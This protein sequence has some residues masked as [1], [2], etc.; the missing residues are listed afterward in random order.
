MK[1]FL[2][3]LMIT[4]A[5]ASVASAQ[6]YLIENPENRPYFGAR[7]GMDITA[8]P[9][10]A[11]YSNYNNG[12]GVSFG[13]VYNIPVYKNLYVEP[14]L[15]IFYDTFKETIGYIDVEH[16]VAFPSQFNRSTRNFGF[17]I[18]LL[19]GYHFD[20]TDQVQIAPFTGPQ[21]NLSLYAHDHFPDYID[22]ESHSL[23][24]EYGFKHVDLQWVIGASVT[25][26]RFVFTASGAFGI[27]RM[28]AYG[29][30]KLRRNTCTLSVGYNFFT[31]F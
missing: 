12:L 24:G 20:F 4:A 8:T 15:S 30:D 29:D 19:A 22:A 16:D 27:T 31:T 18:P 28:S 7:I 21:L 26:D 13:A 14:G 5:S 9:G 11:L 6:N 25:Y 3:G 2:V 1:R 10:S 17:R 23:F